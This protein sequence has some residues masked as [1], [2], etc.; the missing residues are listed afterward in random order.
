MKDFDGR[1]AVVTGGASGIGRA[2]GEAFAAEGM[3]VVLGDVEAPVLEQT[4]KELTAGGLDVPRFA[5]N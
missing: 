3:K 4:V 1:V 5:T 2:M